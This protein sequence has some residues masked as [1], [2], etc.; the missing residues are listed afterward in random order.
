MKDLLRYINRCSDC[1]QVSGPFTNPQGQQGPVGE[2]GPAG[3]DGADGAQGVSIA[4][5]VT[6]LE[7]GDPNCPC[8]GTQI[9]I[10]PDADGDGIPDSITN[11]I[12]NCNGCPGQDASF[13][14]NPFYFIYADPTDDTIFETTGVTKGIGKGIYLGYAIAN[15]NNGTIDMRGMFPMPYSDID[16]TFS[17]VG[18]AAGAKTVTLAKANLPTHQHTVTTTTTDS[19]QISV[20]GGNHTHSYTNWPNQAD[21][22]NGGSS[23]TNNGTATAQTTG[24]TGAHTHTVT[25]TTGNGSTDGLVATPVDKLPPYRVLLL[26]QKI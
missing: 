26:I 2:T 4:Y 20:S 14:F 25:G 5:I 16:A 17:T 18:T 9:D 24:G 3:A 8:S 23:A 6:A 21:I 11:T 7:D 22:G 15:G 1:E 12:Y 19:G 13:A 10:G